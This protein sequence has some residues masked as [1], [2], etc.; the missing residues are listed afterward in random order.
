MKM[1]RQNIRSLVL[2][3]ACAFTSASLL[4]QTD[5]QLDTD[6]NVDGHLNLVIRDANKFD[7][8][9]EVHESIVELPSITY[10]LIPNNN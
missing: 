2:V 6:V 7:S 4:G 1:K 9:P 10:T 5:D 8:W 3:A